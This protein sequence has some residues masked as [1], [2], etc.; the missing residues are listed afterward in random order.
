M[1]W[2]ARR[3]GRADRNFST[4]YTPCQSAGLFCNRSSKHSFN[5]IQKG[6]VRSDLAVRVG[7][8][9]LDVGC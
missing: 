7:P 6:R 1:S 4:R 2:T 8:A 9:W 5:R 3:W